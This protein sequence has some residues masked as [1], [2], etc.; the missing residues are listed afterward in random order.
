MSGALL[1]HL[2]Q[3]TLFCGG[4]WL[5]MFGLRKNAAALRHWLWTLASIKFLLP[6]SLL[7]S[8]GSLARLF[9]A[10]ANQP[11]FFGDALSAAAPVLSPTRTLSL[12]VSA[13][14]AEGP[15]LEVLL[16]GAWIIGASLVLL[17]WFSAWS[18]A[19]K[20]S[21]AAKPA[22]GAPPDAWITDAD[23]EPSAARVFKP[24][25]LL[26]AALLG[27]LTTPQLQAVLA[28][29]R[30]HIARHDNL[31]ANIHRVV[32]ALFWFY[33]LVW[34]IGRRM[35]EERE[36]AC[37][38]AV[39]D[40]G[41]DPA[42]YA[43]GILAV[44]SHCRVHAKAS[45]ARG[46]LAAATAGN[47][48]QRIH[49]ILVAARPRSLGFI[50]AVVLSASTLVVATVP[51]FA[52]AFD[53]ALHRYDLLRR[54]ANALGSAQV[55][56]TPAAPGGPP[57]RTVTVNGDRVVIRNSSLR[58]LV[59]LAYGVE[60]WRIV[61]FDSLLD[62]SHYDVLARLPHPVDEPERFDPLAL[63][64]TVAKLLAGHFGMQIHVNQRCQHPCGRG[65]LDPPDT[66]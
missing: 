11:D 3:S 65:A 56:L 24:V 33:P 58:D 22:P 10:Q 14:A 31:K 8:L 2:W 42:D 30:E 64:G 62:D 44:C 46:P 66:R 20:I 9:P 1:D 39:I 21:R 53:D 25:V 40:A 55:S 57:V 51:V 35:L 18:V 15:G 48:T 52:G 41:H 6:F 49:E 13:V 23:I 7:Y 50:K 27:K 47:L 36:R 19:E 54:Q 63:Q 29:E 32:E 12:P 43:A 45:L 17:H 26:P 5:L 4:V 37:D 34:W 61:G 60:S 16:F 59:A 28:H 38:E